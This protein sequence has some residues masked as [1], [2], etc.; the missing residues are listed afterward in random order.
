MAVA[1][2]GRQLLLLARCD[3]WLRVENATE[4]PSTKLLAPA[5]L[6]SDTWVAEAKRIRCKNGFLSQARQ[7]RLPGMKRR[8]KPGSV[9]AIVQ[10]HPLG[11]S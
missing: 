1:P 4:K 8:I 3:G 7:S 11:I 2:A 10:P 9:G 6:D 5:E